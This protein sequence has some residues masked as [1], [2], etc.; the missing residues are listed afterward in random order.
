M[1]NRHNK[2]TGKS[3]SVMNSRR[4]FLFIAYGNKSDFPFAPAVFCLESRKHHSLIFADFR[5]LA[6]KKRWL[7]PEIRFPLSGGGFPYPALSRACAA[8]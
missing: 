6:V 7:P 5:R 1:F 2:S 4:G 3:P 8:S